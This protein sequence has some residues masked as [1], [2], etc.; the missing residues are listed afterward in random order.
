MMEAVLEA[1]TDLFAERGPD[2]VSIREIAIAAGVNHALVHRH[3][4]SKEALL[5]MTLSRL[6]EGFAAA[7]DPDAPGPSAETLLQPSFHIKA[8][9][10]MMA[11]AILVGQNPRDLQNDFPTIH[12]AI[13]R[14]SVPG[15]AQQARDTRIAVAISAATLLGWLLYEPFIVA[16]AGLDPEDQRSIVRRLDH[17]VAAPRRR[18]RRLDQTDSPDRSTVP[19]PS[20]S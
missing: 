8:Y 4:G 16:A 14:Q 15:N 17:P 2:S 1:A 11:W 5:K 10:R 3:F 13:E 20:G 19:A 7:S 12:Q 6:A 18:A 9:A